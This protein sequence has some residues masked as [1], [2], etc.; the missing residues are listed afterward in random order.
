MRSYKMAKALVDRGCEVMIVC[1][2]YNGGTSGLETSF[3]WGVRSGL[4]DGIHIMEIQIKYSN[5]QSF[6]S[7]VKAFCFIFYS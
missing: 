2:S 3:K 6:A 7:R 4:V 1:G 5:S